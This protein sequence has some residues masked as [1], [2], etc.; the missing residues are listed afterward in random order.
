MEEVITKG[1]VL[2]SVDY[3]E[4]DRLVEIFSLER[5]KLQ[6][7]LKGCKTQNAKLKFA[8]QPFCFAEFLLV[9]KSGYK[10][11]KNAT[12][13][14]SFFEIS[15]NTA[16]YYLST[17]MLEIIRNVVGYNEPN[18]QLFLHLL[19]SLKNIC[20]DE[21]DAQMVVIKFCLT[22]LENQGYKLSFKN[23]SSC[24]IPLT[25]QK[26]LNIDSGEFVCK[27]CASLNHL[28]ISDSAFSALRI[29][30]STENDRL[31]TIKVKEKVLTE[32]LFLIL[33][34]C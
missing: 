27:A 32:S 6:C 3:K 24:K 30:D 14:D 21:K 13:I 25:S 7:L 29:I 23:C 16:N 5:G 17:T 31:N 4:K 34:K 8:F 19:T 20:Y 18:V 10:V 9:D 11:V 28:K 33:Q 22:V 15:Q 12:L 26:F 1:I 2:N